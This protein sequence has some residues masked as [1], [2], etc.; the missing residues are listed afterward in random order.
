MAR[1]RVGRFPGWPRKP[2]ILLASFAFLHFFKTEYLRF[3]YA[4]S[5]IST[6]GSQSAGNPQ[7][8][9]N[10]AWRCIEVVVTRLTRNFGR[11]WEFRPPDSPWYSSTQKI[12]KSNIFCRL[13]CFLSNE[14]L[15]K[16]LE[17]KPDENRHGELSEWSKVQHSKFR[18]NLWF[19]SP[20][21][22]LL[23]P[24]FQNFKSN[25]FMFSLLLFSPKDFAS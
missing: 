10:T 3:F 11:S 8:L 16:F 6:L 2:L 5:T 18:Q 23:I 20:R 7:S 24:G 12:S 4:L 13:S 17:R 1:N 25:I 9:E 21:N 22:P 19:S 14:F 15:S